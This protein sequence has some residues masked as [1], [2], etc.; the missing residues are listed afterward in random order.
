MTTET[1]ADTIATQVEYGD[2]DNDDGCPVCGSEEFHRDSSKSETYC[3]S[4]GA[5]ADED[6]I[7]TSKEY[8]N[9][10]GNNN[11]ERAGSSIT[12]TKAD[13]GM[14]TKIGQGGELNRLSGAKR[15]KYYRMKKWDRRNNSR[16][17]S[18]QKGLTVMKRLS[19]NLNLPNSVREEAGRLYEKSIEKDLI[20]GKKREAAVAALIYLIARNHEVPRTQKEIAEAAGIETRKMNTTYRS[21][22]RDLDLRIRPAK[23]ENFVPRYGS[24]LGFRGKTISRAI[25]MVKKAREKGIT[26][27]KAPVSV[28]AGGLYLAGLLEKEDV[29]QKKLADTVGITNN[30]VR[31]MYRELTDELGLEEELEKVRK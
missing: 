12:Y 31:N 14:S 22:A 29:T 28:A 15:T 7:D 21:L 3:I 5:L 1:V 2:R 19:F 18:V 23:P 30:T 17:D 8:R 6:K 16:Q 10:D 9:F 27:G 24:M 20:K 25:N 26:S 13:K 11:K 4:C